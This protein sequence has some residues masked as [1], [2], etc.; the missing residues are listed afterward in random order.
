MMIV[1]NFEHLASLKLLL[2]GTSTDKDATENDRERT[3]A[4]TFKLSGVALAELVAKDFIS[5]VGTYLHQC[6]T[7]I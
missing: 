4:W 5:Q 6:I 7:S 1:V 3:F 2:G